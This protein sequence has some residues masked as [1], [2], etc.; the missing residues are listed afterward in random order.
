MIH[1]FHIFLQSG[2]A[3]LLK[4]CQH[5]N[6]PGRVPGTRPSDFPTREGGE[7]LLSTGSGAGGL[8]TY[9]SSDVE[10]RVI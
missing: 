3:R 9:R 6:V 7:S 2:E 4:T 5:S 10:I 1:F 8:S